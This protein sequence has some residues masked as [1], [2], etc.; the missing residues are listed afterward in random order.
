V[1]RRGLEPDQRLRLGSRAHARHVVADLGNPSR[2]AGGADLVVES[3]G[4]ELGVG[5]Q[6]RPDD[7][8]EGIELRGS[9]WILSRGRGVDVPLELAGRDPVVHDAAA[10]AEALGDG[11]LRQAVI[12]EMLK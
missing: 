8:G 3:D 12:E 1:A 9:R 6:A 4:G 5:R 2:V 10:D 7:P 11:R